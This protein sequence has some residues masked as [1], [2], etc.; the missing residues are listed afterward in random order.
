MFAAVYV[1]LGVHDLKM[2][3]LLLCGV[4][5]KI[6]SSVIE[7]QGAAPFPLTLDQLDLTIAV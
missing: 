2:R 7:C 6:M 3:F 5:P 1:S 4:G